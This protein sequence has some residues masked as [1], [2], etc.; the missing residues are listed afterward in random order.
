MF[1]SLQMSPSTIGALS[2]S[3]V[4]PYFCCDE[5]EAFSDFDSRISYFKIPTS[6]LNSC[7]I[8]VIKL[9]LSSKFTLSSNFSPFI[10]L[11]AEKTGYLTVTKNCQKQ[12]VVALLH[13]TDTTEGESVAAILI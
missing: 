3:V 1:K 10:S 4:F 8:F 5:S 6:N 7:T 13:G 12:S 9:I 2:G 11:L